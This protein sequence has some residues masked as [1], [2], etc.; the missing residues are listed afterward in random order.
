M[1]APNEV[2]TIADIRE[3]AVA[4]L[5][6]KWAA[7]LNEGAMDLVT[8]KANETAYDRY[9]IM[10]RI[11][12]DVSK[13]D[14]SANMFGT[15]VAMPF[16]FSPAAM[17]C[18]AHEDGELGTS[19]AAAKAGVPMGLSQWA[20]KSLEEV[21]AAGKSVQSTN[22]CIPYGI[23]TSGAARK[24][25][26][27]TLIKRAEK[28]GFKALLLTV[29]APTIGRR[30][31]EYRNGIDLPE[32]LKFPNLSYDPKNF[33]DTKR[34]AGTTFSE[35]IPWLSSVTPPSME[36]WLKGI[37]TPEDVMLA[38]QY[39]RVRGVIVSNHGGR[40]LD[41]APATLEALPEC[42]A[43]ARSINASRTA[44]NKLMVGIDG[45]IRRGS[46]IFK[47]LA[48]GADFC[49]AGR[50]PIWGLAYNGQQGV[51]RAL[52]LLRDELEMCMRL[53]G[54]KSIAEIGRESLAVVEGGVPGLITRLSKL[55]RTFKLHFE[56]V[57]FKAGGSLSVSYHYLVQQN[58]CDDT[59]LAEADVSS[60][61]FSVSATNFPTPND[62]HGSGRIKKMIKPTIVFLP[63]AWLTESCYS[64]LLSSLKKEGFPVHY[65]QYPSLNPS[66]QYI[67]DA[68]CQR[69]ATAIL[70]Q[71]I[72]PLIEDQG[73]D[74][75]LFMHSYASMPGSA[76]ARGFSKSERLRD[77]KAGGVVGLVCIGAFLVPEGLSCAGLQGG[78]LPGWILV[79]QPEPGVNIAEDP[80][81]NFA[82]DVSEDLAREMAM[83][84][85]PHSNSAFMSNQPAP[86][87]NEPAFAGRCAYIVT[88]EDVAVPKAAQYGMIAATGQE[89]IMKELAGC[90]HMAPFTTRVTDCINVLYEIFDAFQRC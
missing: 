40:Q 36:I 83:Q 2:Y 73:Q 8:V 67:P 57:S 6:P 70:N 26:I 24:E 32:N 82:A 25:D 56:A 34:D 85:K 46:D 65:A 69:D 42:A 21:I 30:L 52:E 44:A 87:W 16:G 81:K 64:P 10:P 33:R 60:P 43:A 63:G 22:C 61:H 48:L 86:A 41:G 76:A 90:S 19:R 31:N 7:Y 17:H 38:A 13:V 20:T 9:R 3:A 23:Q 28:A 62:R 53:A 12:R 80:V 66:P 51:E 78:N 45:G 1:P 50:I 72:K 35:F 11:L 84:L 5:D 18:L 54:C 47:A 68:D 71:A 89:W 37:Y 39:P 88:E 29:D 77:G 58:Y 4:K 79:D 15:K 49:F 74:V 55:V 14:T 27:V 59:P 75:I